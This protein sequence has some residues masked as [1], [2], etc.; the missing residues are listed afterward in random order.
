MID[1]T[2]KFGR[3]V[4]RHLNKEYFV[5]LTTVGSDLTPQPRPVWF[6]WDKD[7]L[8]IF[9]QAKAHKVKH[10]MQ[11]SKVALHFNSSDE[12]AEKEVI[13][14]IGEAKI[15]PSVP[16][17]HKV[18]AYFKKYKTGIARLGGTPEDFSNE[19]SVAI[20]VKPTSVRGW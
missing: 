3:I 6:I 7:S 13:V 15:D 19:Y 11:H 9:S 4:K 8:L 1:L 14:M 2:S 12:L 20:R 10:L 17:A 18:P 5:W 16:P